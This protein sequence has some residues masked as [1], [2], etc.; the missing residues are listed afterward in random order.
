M[1]LVVASDNQ[2]RLQDRV[3]ALDP[4]VRTFHTGYDPT[5]YLFEFGKG[6]I[7][8]I[9]RI[10]VHM[11]SLQSRIASDTNL[12]HRARYR[13]CRAWRKMHWRIRNLVDDCHKKIVKFLCANY[14]V[15]LLPSF[16]THQMVIRNQRK[17]RSK[18]VRAMLTWSHYRFKQRLLFKRQEYPWCK[19]AV[20]NEAYT[21]KTCGCCGELHHKLGGN[22]RFKCPT[23]QTEIDRDVNGA[24]NI[25]LKNASFFDFQVGETLGLTPSLEFTRDCMVNGGGAS[26][27]N[28]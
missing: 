27:K 23:C 10:C 28:C 21:S 1:P 3:I 11:D 6:D 24:R 26:L 12:R 7:G 4:G 5:G 2:A 13:M 15:V 18:T 17:I 8:H 25:L 19:V 16:E 14:S 22:K 20:C 9:Y